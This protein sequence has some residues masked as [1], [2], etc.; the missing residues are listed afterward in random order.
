MRGWSKGALVGAWAG[1]AAGFAVPASAYE[2]GYGG[3]AFDTGAFLNAPATTPPPGLYGSLIYNQVSLTIR[4]PGAP[5][6]N[7]YAGNPTDLYIA[8]PVEI[9]SYVPGF[10]LL[11]GVYSFTFAQQE[12]VNA[13]NTPAN[14]A[15]EGFHNSA[16]TPIS[17]GYKLSEGL[18]AKINLTAVVPDGTQD[19]FNGLGNAGVPFTTI[20][21]R[22]TTTYEKNGITF[23]NNI[24]AELNT[25]NPITG[26]TTGVILRDE[27]TLT[28]TFS[29]LTIGPAIA[30]I[31]QVT[32]DKSSFYYRYAI[33]TNRYNQLAAGGIIGYDFGAVS[34]AVYGLNQ[35][36]ANASGGTP[37]VLGGPD[38]A[39]TN[40][41]LNIFFQASFKFPGIGALGQPVDFGASKTT[42]AR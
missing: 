19:G 2:S 29:R 14:F 27:A 5:Y 42:A 4:G 10:T 8:A 17:L 26:Y 38:T 33:N 30:Y 21:P 3:F 7:G 1:L 24:G 32:D 40:G 6:V 28:A 22:L 37:R 25:E 35:V 39:T 36:F 31:G 11:G 34:L 16:I 9:I 23:N 41:G 20:F 13:A 18:Y 15:R 12:N